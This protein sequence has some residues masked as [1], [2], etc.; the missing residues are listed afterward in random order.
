MP[1][2]RV[3][4]TLVNALDD[5]DAVV[6]YEASEVLIKRNWK[7]G[8]EKGKP[9]KVQFNLPVAYKLDKEAGKKQDKSD[10]AEPSFLDVK[11]TE[12]KK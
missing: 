1:G 9:V 5:D 12:K 6:R 2:E 8:K 3:T 10:S 11:K 4:T 7:P